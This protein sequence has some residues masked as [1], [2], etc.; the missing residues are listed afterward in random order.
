MKVVIFVALGLLAASD[1]AKAG[2]TAQ[3]DSKPFTLNKPAQPASKPPPKEA[4]KPAAPA[5]VA[6]APTKPKPK[7]IADCGKAKG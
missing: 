3:C 1:G 5:K 2:D 6:S 4:G 7:P